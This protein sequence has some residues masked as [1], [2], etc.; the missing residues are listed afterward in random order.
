[1]GYIP[2]VCHVASYLLLSVAM[3]LSPFDTKRDGI[4]GVHVRQLAYELLFVPVSLSRAK[5][6]MWRRNGEL[7]PG[8]A[9]G[10]GLDWVD[11]LVA[12]AGVMLWLGMIQVPCDTNA[13]NVVGAD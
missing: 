2:V 7:Q 3:L 12:F 10:P 4:G 13:V 8:T 9:V 6:V 5:F 1:M 11:V